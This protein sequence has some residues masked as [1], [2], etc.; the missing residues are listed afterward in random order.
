[1]PTSPPLRSAVRTDSRPRIDDPDAAL[2]AVT[3]FDVAGPGAQQALFDASAAA[4]AT[5]PWP[6]TLIAIT[7]LAS[8][9]G[10][11]AL[12]Y[13]QWRSESGFEAFGRT[14][15][16]VL[17]AHFAAAVPDAVA[18]P[19]AFYRRYRSAVA[20]DAP[21]PGCIVVVQ[22]TFDGPDAARQA[23]WV[24]AVFDALAA[25]PPPPG[26]LAAHF[27]LSTDGTRVL[28]WA[29]WLDEASHRDALARSGQATI[30][31]GPKWREVQAWPGLANG[32]V[33]RY[34]F[35]RRLVPAAGAVAT[36]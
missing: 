19:V 14:H 10:R 35:D 34:R 7:W 29:E 30:G 33:T 11:R 15:R 5:L 27:H 24:D 22:A 32:R 1:M 23:A 6:E 12:A 36:T 8:T 25:E 17:S 31:A 18:T 20:P 13:A 26:G 16:P 9:D 2:A 4:W 3:E 28:N 21:P